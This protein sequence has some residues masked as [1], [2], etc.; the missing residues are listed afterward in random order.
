MT[1]SPVDDAKERVPLE[2]EGVH[3]VHVAAHRVLQ[4]LDVAGEEDLGPGELEEAEH[5]GE[6]GQVVAGPR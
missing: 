6:Q 1:H 3:H 2:Q 5:D 4:V